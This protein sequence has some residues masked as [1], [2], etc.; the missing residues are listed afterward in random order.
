[1]TRTGGDELFGPLPTSVGSVGTP[2]FEAVA[3]A[4]FRDD[5]RRPPATGTPRAT[6]SGAPP[7]PPRPAR[8]PRRPPRAACRGAAQATGSSRRRARRSPRRRPDER[9]P[10]RVRDR[11]AT[12][13]RGLQQ[14][15]HRAADAAR[16]TPTAPEAWTAE[17]W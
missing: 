5:E 16:P 4:W 1:M 9:V 8:T 2:I 7:R 10:E 14:G 15:R 12:Y 11:L 6:A 3:S 13:Q 17:G